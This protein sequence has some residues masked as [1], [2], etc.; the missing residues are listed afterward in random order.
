MLGVFCFAGFADEWGGRGL[1]FAEFVIACV[2]THQ[3]RKKRRIDRVVGLT[4]LG[5]AKAE[6]VSGP[7]VY[8]GKMSTDRSPPDYG[9]EAPAGKESEGVRDAR[10]V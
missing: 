6:E 8:G 5:Y 1:H 10:E 9:D 2:E 3:L 4:D 7:P